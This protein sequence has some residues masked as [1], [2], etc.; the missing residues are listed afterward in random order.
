QPTAEPQRRR[1]TQIAGSRL[2]CAPCHGVGHSTSTPPAQDPSIPS[3]QSAAT[4][5]LDPT[6]TGT[7]F[8]AL[9]AAVACSGRSGL[10][11]AIVSGRGCGTG[12]FWSAREGR[13][14]GL[15]EAAAGGP[16]G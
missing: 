10:G 3:D 8:A 4:A 16:R 5:R 9:W 12:G 1:K 11:P 2:H 15:A 7:S 14:T 13:T 6:H